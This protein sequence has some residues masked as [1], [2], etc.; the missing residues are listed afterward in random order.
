MIEP[1]LQHKVALVTGANAGIGAAIARALAAQGTAVAIHY[2][3]D[4]PSQAGVMHTALG[5][6]A[7]QEVVDSIEAAG[8]RA[9]A[10]GG[11]LADANLHVHLFDETQVLLGPVDILINNAAHCEDAD[12]LSAIDAGVIDRHFAINV[13]AATLLSQQLAW[14][15]RERDAI[16]GCIVNISTDA[17]RA[18]PGQIA[19]G[20][21]KY[22]LESLT[23]SLAQ[24][25]GPQGIR[26]NT[27]SPGPVQTGW[28][29]EDLEE[30]LQETIPLRRV[31]TPED[32]ADAVTFLCSHQ[33]RWITGQVVQVA[34]GHAL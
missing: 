31:G 10:L 32:V 30:T 7:A 1:R 2:L 34:G 21:S 4:I 13:R 24:E 15:C 9:V 23:R 19:Y 6:P 33:A 11:D 17:A 20:A 3:A 26:V 18:F 12:T 8:G 29:S 14:R 25:L 16:D 22:A 5:Q 27:I 28:I